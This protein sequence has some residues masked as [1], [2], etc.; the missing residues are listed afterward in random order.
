ML[1]HRS[2]PYAIYCFVANPDSFEECLMD[3][4][5]AGGDRDTIG[6][7][8]AAVSGARLGRGALPA[9]WTGKLENAA[10]IEE[11]ALALFELRFGAG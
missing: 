7:M 11:L 1:I 4:V 2:V 8:A 10:Y 3:A 9:D 5:L 6:A